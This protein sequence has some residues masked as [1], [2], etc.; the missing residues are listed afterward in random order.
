MQSLPVPSSVMV[1]FVLPCIREARLRYG[2]LTYV[3]DVTRC[4]GSS[5]LQAFFKYKEVDTVFAGAL[6]DG[7]AGIAAVS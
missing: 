7:I 1:G 3:V 5:H 6:T 4:V 2:L